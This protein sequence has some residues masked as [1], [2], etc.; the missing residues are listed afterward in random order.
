MTFKR[1]KKEKRQEEVVLLAGGTGGHVFPAQLLAEAFEERGIKILFITD[2]RGSVYVKKNASFKCHVLDM[3]SGSFLKRLWGILR[4]VGGLLKLLKQVKP[5][6]VLGFGGYPS[7]SGAIAALLLRIPLCL[8]EQNAV[9]GRVNRVLFPFSKMLFLTFSKTQK[10][11]KLI[12]RIFFLKKKWIGPLVRP[13]IEAI[14]QT[15]PYLASPPTVLNK[16]QVLVLGGSQGSIRLTE[17]ILKALKQIPSEIR[18]K[19]F[20]TFQAPESQK[21]MVQEE[22]HRLGISHDVAS[23]FSDVEKRIAKTHLV[24]A[25]AGS[26]TIG[27]SLATMR[28]ALFIPL[29]SA[30][31]DHQ[32]KNAS[33]IVSGKGGWM[34]TQNNL[35]EKNIIHFLTYLI[36][37]PQELQHA[38]LNLSKMYSRGALEKIMGSVDVFLKERHK[39][40]DF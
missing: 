14:G 19:L 10:I 30:M 5:K 17:E 27:E 21:S 33:F 35:L 15:V 40:T 16:F 13:E 26:S 6:V 8:H 22:L 7:A 36:K 25:R 18:A 1:G 32:T 37:N 34:I 38:S 20:I 28:P 23:F 24:I 4:N 12:T 9:L 3:A 29:P 31:D 2:Q 39:E 11:P